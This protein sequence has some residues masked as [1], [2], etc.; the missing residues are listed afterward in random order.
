MYLCTGSNTTKAANR[1]P[2][3]DPSLSNIEQLNWVYT[4]GTCMNC[5]HPFTFVPDA[6]PRSSRLVLPYH[7]EDGTLLEK[8]VKE[9]LVAPVIAEVAA[10]HL[11]QIQAAT[12][13]GQAP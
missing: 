7:F 1:E 9:A 8:I 13:E 12:R 4:S 3:P 11:A 10:R 5:L 2:R 6:N